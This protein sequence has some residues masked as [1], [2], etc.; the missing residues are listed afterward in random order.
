MGEYLSTSALGECLFH[1]RVVAESATKNF[2]FTALV[3]L[4]AAVALYLIVFGPPFPVDGNLR[5]LT[6][7]F[8]AALLASFVIGVASQAPAALLAPL[9]WARARECARRVRAGSIGGHSCRPK[10]LA[11]D[12]SAVE[13][14][15][16]IGAPEFGSYSVDRDGRIR[17]FGCM[18]AGGPCDGFLILVLDPNKACSLKG[19]VEVFT[20][21]GGAVA[22]LEPAG[23]GLVKVR[24]S[25]SLSRGQ[26]KLLLMPYGIP[27][28]TCSKSGAHETVVDLRGFSE[29]I[30]AAVKDEVDVK[31]IAN[32]LKAPAGGL[33]GSR[34][35][36]VL[37]IEAD[38]K[39]IAKEERG[40]EV[41]PAQQV[42]SFSNA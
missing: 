2:V 16:P 4:Y 39:V 31:K 12:G 32:M 21:S 34:V 7:V 40:L 35:S 29:P 24:M 3:L 1:M 19:A 26:A 6:S 9:E 5:L 11:S 41:V 22:T 37:R 13:V 38:G 14:F 17:A 20:Q 8:A 36:A 23:P 18:V 25:C 27:I 42:V 15:D 10:M 33:C 28:A 30:V